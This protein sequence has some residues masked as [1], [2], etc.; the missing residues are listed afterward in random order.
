MNYRHQFHAG[1]FADVFK[2]VLLLQLLRAL[3]KKPRGFVYL[4]THAGR[5]TYDLTAASRGASLGRTPE[6]P[7]GIGRLWAQSPPAAAVRDYLDLV[8]RCDAELGGTSEGPRF[9]PGSPW[10]AQ[11][12][13]RP[14][15]RLVLCEKHPEEVLALAAQFRDTPRT[16]VQEIDGYVAVRATLPPPERRALV[17]VD[18]P[19][20]ALD[21]FAGVARAVGEGLERLAN[22]VF[23]IW[24]PLTERA[25]R[26]ELFSALRAL[27]PPPT[28]A[29]ELAVA[30]EL[31]ALK[32]RGCGLVVV[33]PPWRFEA[34]A[35]PALA[36]LGAAFIQETGG[37]T[38]SEWLVPES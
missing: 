21:E 28:V 26:E 23:A 8:R 24:Y 7:D 6:W 3:Q 9:Y 22:A 36:A 1:N 11:A 38:R 31:S 32:L 33:N 37:G 20:E 29:F 5:G 16:R 13:A 14:Q 34:D 12:V 17:L 27:P 30:G 10:L 35:Q 15:E 19:Y 4:D 2:H 18:P 25:P